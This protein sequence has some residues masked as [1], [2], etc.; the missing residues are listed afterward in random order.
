MTRKNSL[1]IRFSDIEMNYIRFMAKETGKE[2]GPLVRE[3][4]FEDLEEFRKGVIKIFPSPE[5]KAKIKN[6]CKRLGISK[7]DFVSSL[8]IKYLGDEI[9]KEE[10]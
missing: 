10:K 6:I 1:N 3:I 7:E 4:V 2:R 9:I 8:L 5:I